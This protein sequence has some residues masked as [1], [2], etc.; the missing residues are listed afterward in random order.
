VGNAQESDRSDD[1]Y[2][3]APRVAAFD[4]H[5][6]LDQGLFTL[7]LR[8]PT[9]PSSSS[10]RERGQCMG[11]Y[12]GPYR[13]PSTAALYRGPSTAAPFIPISRG[14]SRR[15]SDNYGWP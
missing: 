15:D 13:G 10:S 3:I 5:S 12:R 2:E 9:H 8:S 11:V 1:R 4:A 14:L 6:R 7:N